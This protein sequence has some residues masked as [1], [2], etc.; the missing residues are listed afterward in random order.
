MW[1]WKIVSFTKKTSL[2]IL[3]DQTA[4][5]SQ[6]RQPHKRKMREPKKGVKEAEK[7][8]T[9]SS[10]SPSF[11]NLSVSIKENY[12][13]PRLREPSEKDNPLRKAGRKQYYTSANNGQK[14]A[15]TSASGSYATVVKIE[16]VAILLRG[17]LST[18][19]NS[20]SFTSCQVWYQGGKPLRTKRT[21]ISEII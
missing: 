2:P 5:T 18:S 11:H 17:S 8:I 14:M 20:E 13:P 16:R 10:F 6:V 4:S 19:F 21:Y 3:S 1:R 12:L 9:A 15:I 7:S